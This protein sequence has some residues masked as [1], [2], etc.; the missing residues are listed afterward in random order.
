[1]EAGISRCARDSSLRSESQ[2]RHTSSALNREARRGAER[3]S[4]ASQ[5]PNSSRS[6]GH[7]SRHGD[8]ASSAVDGGQHH[9]VVQ[10]RGWSNGVRIEFYAPGVI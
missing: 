5:N 8:A 10:M 4:V 9:R 1:V 2:P 6:G 7:L 3:S